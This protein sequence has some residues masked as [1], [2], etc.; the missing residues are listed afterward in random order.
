[1]KA[2]L[3][4]ILRAF[5]NEHLHACAVGACTT[6][7]V[8]MIVIGAQQFQARR[9]EEVYSLVTRADLISSVPLED[10]LKE[11]N[12]F[13]EIKE[14]KDSAESSPS[15]IP[16][17]EVQSF[18]SSS[19]STIP[20]LVKQEIK[21][22]SVPSSSSSS[23]AFQEK[24]EQRMEDRQS[25]SSSSSPS[26]VSS[27]SSVSSSSSSYSPP[28]VHESAP[29]AV[30]GEFPAFDHT[31]HPVAKVP[32]WGA[33]RTPAEWNRSFKEM[34]EDDFVA[35]PQYDLAVLTQ[36]MEELTKPLRAENYP[37]ITAKLYYSTRFFSSYDI[38]AGE[39][40]GKHAGIDLKL[41]RGTPL[42]AIA[43][44]RVSSVGRLEH[45]GL[46]VI[47]EHRLPDGSTVYSIYGH[48]DTA[49]VKAGDD[50]APG[51]YI[52]NVGMTGSTTNPHLHLQIDKGQPGETSHVPYHTESIPS[53]NEAEQHV[54][55]PIR[56]LSQYRR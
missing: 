54:L 40:T 6:V 3:R 45:L 9:A 46:T 43:G 7:M 51:T 42:G 8:M 53:P 13:T 48:L 44:G 21:P 26:S 11:F 14:F 20:Q 1:M 36:P 32:N 22:E 38:D 50:V 5:T 35:I 12:E 41:A 15:I 25:S 55:H 31:S 2:S 16:T 30:T 56:F 28:P 4:E 33:M 10:L 24:I 34:N 17:Q 27:N 39:F 23:A 37:L 47:I 18:S 19:S 49:A 52:G 29:P